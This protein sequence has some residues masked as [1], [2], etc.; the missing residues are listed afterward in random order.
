MIDRYSLP[1]MKALWDLQNKYDTWLKVEL[2]VVE[3]QAEVG[4]IPRREADLILKN[5]RFSLERAL[6]IE[7]TTRH[8]LLGFVGAVL[9]NLGAEGRYFHYGV[10]SYDI[11]DPALS[12]LMVQALDA[13]L[14]KLD[15]LIEAV[16]RR[17]REHKYTV[18]MGRTHGIHAEPITLGFKL[19]VW[20]AEFMRGRERVV[21]ARENVAWGKVSG[22]VGTHANISPEV[23]RR[24]CERLGLQPAPASTQILQRDRHAEVLLTLAILSASV[25]KYATEI[26]NLQRTE[27]RELE[28]AFAK[29]Q[30]GSSAMPHKR[31]PSVCEQLSG[32]ARVVR[33]NVVPALE[34]VVTWH[35]RDLANSSVERVIIPDT[36]TL[37]HYQVHTFAGIV[38]EMKV[39]VP[40]MEANLEKMH[41][42]VF[43]QQVMLSLVEKGASREDAYKLSQQL[44][45]EGWQ[46]SDFRRAVRENP[47]VREYLTPEEIERCFDVRYHLKHLDHTFEQLGI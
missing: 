35:E 14:Q 6:E 42:L 32:L 18:M 19:A 39:Y 44:A 7:R 25:E 34:N 27:V 5:A 46:G 3:A 11:E 28:E 30:R 26:R 16:R 45:M 29:G 43:S 21:R 13:I 24:V 4:G 1:E 33:G 20:L 2:A 23:E 31:N 12:L 9:E 41:G 17:A 37:V 10:T 47:Q 36:T 8:D 38:R 40:N 22:A 15:G